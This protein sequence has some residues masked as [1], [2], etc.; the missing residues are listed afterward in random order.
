MRFAIVAVLS[1]IARQS[2]AGELDSSTARMIDRALEQVQEFRDRAPTLEYDAKVHV[3]EW[4]G[5]GSVR[6]TADATMMVR[7]G[8]AHQITYLSREVHGRVKLPD[9]NDD[10]KQDEKEKT[11]LQDF[12]REHRIKERFDFNV[13]A[14]PE[15]IAA[16]TARKIEFAP[17]AHQA[18]KNAADRFLDAIE[19]SAWITE[20]KERFGKFELRLRRPFQIF[21]IFAVLK[22]LSITYESLEPDEF[23][24]H[25]RLKVSFWLATPIYTLR[26][27]HDA[28]LDH[29]RKRDS[30]V[31]AR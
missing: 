12:A 23:L 11:T 5:K 17:R 9:A 30:T 18:E 29:F 21:W 14:E 19:G 13:A 27:E 26:Q 25:S 7:P 3:T 31:A 16:G 2:L 20:Q 24:G 4:N 10:S 28:E 22:E 6:G 15:Q 1:I 8:D